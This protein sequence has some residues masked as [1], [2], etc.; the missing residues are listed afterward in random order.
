MNRVFRVVWNPSQGIWAV[1]SELARGVGKSGTKAPLVAMVLLG[2]AGT[3]AADCASSGSNAITCSAGAPETFV[4]IGGYD[5]T[6]GGSV[7]V[8]PNAVIS[9][10]DL[11][12]I[13][14][15]DNGTILIQRD[16]TVQNNAAGSANGH[17]GTGA[18]TIE[19]RSGTTLT[20]E[21]G[22]KVLSNGTA[23]NAEAVN[24]HGSANLI[25]N[26]G[27]IRSQ[28]GGAAIWFESSDGANTVVNGASG[29]IEYKGGAG[30]IMGVAGTMAIAFTNQG[31]LI[32]SLNFANANDTFNVHTGSSI[33]GSID[34]GG[35]SNLLTL[36]GSG[37]DT[38][39][40]TL[41]NFQTLVKNDSG[42]WTFANALPGSGI[43]STRVAGGTLILGA[44]ASGYTGSMTVDAA[45]ILQTSAQF[46][47]LAIAD[48]GLVR[49]A[50]PDDATYTGLLSGTGGIEKTGAGRLTL[51]SD[52]AISGT[53]T[54]S[55][56]T[57]QLGDG[58][59]TGMVSGPIVDNAALVVNRSNAVG[60]GAPI[61]GTGSVTQLGTGT[62]TFTADNSYTGGTIITGGTLQ[63]GNGGT[64]GSVVGDIVNNATLIANRS[65][66]LNLTGAIS[67]SGSLR[68]VGSGTTVLSG[69]NSYSGATM[70]AAG[71]LKAG[72]DHTFSAASAHTV[73]SGAT[74]DAAGFHQRVASLDN[75]GT[76]NLLSAAAGST[77]TVTGAYVGNRGV[78][79]LGTVLGGSSSLSDRLVLSGPA[80]SASGNTTVRI[81][82]LG[83]LGAQ[84]TGNGIEVVS[85]RN[86]A[87]T[88]AQS[89][90][91]AFA[92]ADGH[93]D[94]G[95]YEYRLYA[96]DAQGAGENWYL[97]SETT[98]AP[99]VAPV[100]ADAPTTTTADSTVKLA[101]P[102]VTVPTYRAEV[103]L[104][105]ALPAQLRQA[106][107]GM[108]G[109]LHRRIGDEAAAAPG[110]AGQAAPR[111]AWARAVYSDLDIGQVGVASAHSRGH[112]SGLQAGTD[113]L[114]I[115]NWRAGLYVGFLDGGAGVSGNARGTLGRVGSTDL[116]S[117]YLGG[118]ATWMAASGL[119][120]DAVLQA[121]RHRSTVRPDGNPNA[122]GKA[123]SLTASIEAGKSFPLAANWTLEPQAQLIYQRT[124]FDDVL[125]GGAAV[126]Q[127]A[128]GGWIGR[129]GARIKGDI[130]TGAGRLQPYVRANLYRASGGT[131][132]AEFI[133]P[134]AT[135]RIA[136]ASGYSS[137][138][139]AGG[140][141]LAVTPATSIYG[142]VGRV[143]ALG[144]DARVKSSVQGSVGVKLRW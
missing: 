129:L 44:D 73:A 66:T 94:A 71:A 72:A 125:I 106:D 79:Q 48:N 135:T 138:E 51:T 76:V 142:E 74:L 68:Q 32:G 13:S 70:V 132:V 107:L 87:T 40:Q 91:D 105:A 47:P 56:G 41:S 143:F 141:T 31:Q 88:T 110:D 14:M 16:A 60:F 17:Y 119:Y 99:P 27:E 69:A 83:G 22:A 115:G 25:V 95:A 15:G 20:V 26:H 63:L 89:T 86:G 90:R 24:A 55:A 96:A 29:V 4:V 64:S 61:S 58:G 52:Q 124:R 104:F 93:V 65:N 123:E 112:V 77:L 118:Y 67:G 33:T 144:G 121:G 130:A 81:T 10:I 54:I 50:Q 57:L 39:A 34:G 35:G 78:L 3:A 21:E 2:M 45:G 128:D 7:D 114:A 75:A 6:P 36:N 59:T 108:L 136:S 126:R 133:G 127:H 97:R 82:N 9:T 11:P 37:S 1:A 53:T 8:Q 109:N 12:A 140:F 80:A 92:L 42:T 113:L 116:Q 100:D 139:V 62:T 28:A 101:L 18:N 120:A 103:P 102:L 19:F 43:T 46:A 131:D 85:A 137:G 84:T 49:F 98:I 111:R 38:F 5:A 122:S 30:N 117:R 23:H 134:A